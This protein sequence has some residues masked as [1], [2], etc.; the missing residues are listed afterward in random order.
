LAQV[1]GN[2][3]TNAGKY[4]EPGGHIWLT[5]ERLGSDVAVSVKDTGVGIPPEMVPKVFDVFTQVGRSLERSQGGLGIGLSL[6]KRLVEMHGGTVTARS[7]GAG[8]GSEFVVRLPILIAPPMAPPRPELT[9]VPPATPARRILIV[10]DN[11]DSADTLDMLLALIGNET[12]TAKD[13]VE[14]VEKAAAFRPDVI[15]LD[16]GLPKMNGYE[17]CRTIREQPWGHDIV[18]VALTGWGQEEDRRQSKEAGFNDHMVKP[19]D[20]DALLKLLASLPS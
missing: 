5:A 18:M 2:L 7:D 11:Q 3:L 14:A 20:H 8:R 16:I 6:V 1:L 13:G 4:T 19:V 9:R 15:L 12:E 17:T 10:D